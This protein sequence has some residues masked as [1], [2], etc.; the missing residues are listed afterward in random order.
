MSARGDRRHQLDGAARRPSAS[1]GEVRAPRQRC[2]GASSCRRP[3]SR[4]LLPSPFPRE[5]INYS[6]AGQGTAIAGK[7]ANPRPQT[8]KARRAA[9]GQFSGLFFRG[10]ESARGSGSVRKSCSRSPDLHDRGPKSHAGGCPTMS[11]PSLEGALTEHRGAGFPSGVVRLPIWLYDFRAEPSTLLFHDS[12]ITP[13]PPRFRTRAAR[14]DT[15]SRLSSRSSSF[16]PSSRRS[17]SD[18]TDTSRSSRRSRPRPAGRRDA[19]TCC[20]WRESPR[21]R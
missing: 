7:Y 14:A 8:R 1:A 11:A 6:A 10:P 12:T 15:S 17:S 13:H 21:Q 18:A 19:R 3:P 9:S 20:R 16:S 2:R 5:K 4:S